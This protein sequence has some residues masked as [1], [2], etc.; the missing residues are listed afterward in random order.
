[1]DRS[2]LPMPC[3][4][5]S[6][7]SGRC[8][9]YAQQFAAVEDEVEELE[10]LM[11]Q[12]PGRG[13]LNTALRLKRRV[14]TQRRLVA[15]L[16]EVLMG[17]EEADFPWPRQA[18]THLHFRNLLGRL[19]THLQRLDHARDVLTSSYN[20]S[21]CPAWATARTSSCACSLW[22]RPCCYR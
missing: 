19:D 10:E 11:I 7:E 2:T 15:P 18:D 16:R 14:Q 9:S 17:L 6:Q 4:D 20:L 13:A 8:L 5:E 22:S 12:Q 21:I 1:M 3:F